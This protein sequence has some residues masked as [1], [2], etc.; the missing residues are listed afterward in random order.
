MKKLDKHKHFIKY[1]KVID[2]RMVVAA[3]DNCLKLKIIGKR[4]YKLILKEVMDGK[5]NK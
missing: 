1:L 2:E 4:D 3:L 5:D